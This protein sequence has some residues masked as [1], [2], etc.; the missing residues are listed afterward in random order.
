MRADELM[1]RFVTELTR[2]VGA[3]LAT[4]ASTRTGTAAQEDGFGV[5]V[6]ATHARGQLR[7]YFGRTGAEALAKATSASPLEPSE[8]RILESLKELCGQ[9]LGAFAPDAGL[10]ITAVEKAAELPLAAEGIGCEIV[11]KGFE[12]P[13][14]IVV[15]GDLELTEMAVAGIPRSESRTLDVIMDIDLPLVVRFGRTEL[16]LKTLTALGPGSV[17]DLGRA[18]DDPVD[19]LISNRIVARGEVVIVAGNYGVRV[20]DVVSPAE[21]ARSLE[22]ELS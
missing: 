19:V 12:T 6:T 17:I 18:P 14:R 8:A 20:H 22:A 15:V 1:G 4:T 10:R 11:A 9:T 13:L 5:T 21:R 3:L 16:P 7:V 2:V